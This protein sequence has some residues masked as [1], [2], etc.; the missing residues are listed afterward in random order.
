MY[1]FFQ[2][3]NAVVYPYVVI[4]FLQLPYADIG[5]YSCVP[6]SWI[7]GRRATDRKSLVAYPDESP[8]IT[9]LRIM[10][11][12]EPSEKWELYMAVIKHESRGYFVKYTSFNTCE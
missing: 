9:K 10:N 1:L 2:E 4:Q 11:G 3:D 6:H 8:S 7:R 5:D 12:D